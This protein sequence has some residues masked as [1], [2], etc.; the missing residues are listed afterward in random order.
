MSNQ[1]QEQHDPGFR[2][3]D[4]RRAPNRAEEKQADQ[5]AV[6]SE[7]APE[8]GPSKPTPGEAAEPGAEQQ[9][10]LEPVDVNAIVEYC[11][12]LLNAQAWQW[13]GLVKNPLTGQ[14]ER[15]LEQARVAIDCIEALFKQVEPRLG[16]TQAR[17]LRQVLTDLRVNFVRQSSQQS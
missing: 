1:N 6:E 16:E 5:G 4:K 8:A 11:I 10:P 3:V 9:V 2:I 15:D 13:M 17:Q 7:P 14:I 12:S